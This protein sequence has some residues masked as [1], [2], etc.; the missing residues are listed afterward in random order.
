[1]SWERFAIVPEN[2]PTRYVSTHRDIDMLCHRWKSPHGKTM[3]KHIDVVSRLN[4]PASRS[5]PNVRR[6]H[7]SP[8]CCYNGWP[9]HNVSEV[10]ILQSSVATLEVGTHFVV[11]H[12]SVEEVQ[13]DAVASVLAP[14]LGIEVVECAPIVLVDVAVLH[15]KSLRTVRNLRS[16]AL[17]NRRRVEFRVQYRGQPVV[18][19]RCRE[20][21]PIVGCQCPFPCQ[22][23]L[24]ERRG[25]EP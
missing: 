14:F 9:Q 4:C 7:R 25:S 20:V 18:T 15:K 24:S 19:R 5:L 11:S 22:P 16:K 1:M 17:S 2:C 21:N 23:P 10:V 13:A 12:C 6:Q 3:T 8:Q